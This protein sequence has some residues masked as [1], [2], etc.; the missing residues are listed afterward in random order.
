MNSRSGAV[1]AGLLFLFSQAGFAQAAG[2]DFTPYITLG[3]I[4]TDNVTLAPAGEEQDEFITL[5]NPG[6]VLGREAGRVR[7]KIA[8]QMQNLFY[9]KESDFNETHH[10]LDAIGVAEIVREHFYVDATSSI[11]QQ[12]IN[13]EEA[14]GLS[15]VSVT[16]NRAD[17]FTASVSPY[18]R[19][20]FGSTMA[21]LARYRYGIVDYD[22]GDVGELTED[23]TV[24]GGLLAL[25]SQPSERR[26]AWLGAYSR[27]RVESEDADATDTF[28]QAGLRLDYR[29]T[30]AIGLVALGGYEDNEFERTAVTLD[31]EGTFWEAGLRLEPSTRDLIELR[32]GERFFGN[33]Y[34][35]SWDHY[36][37]R[38]A[39]RAAYSEDVTTVAQSL[40][41]GSD[42][43][44]N[45]GILNPSPDIDLTDAGD[46][47]IND[48]TVIDP[49]TGVPIDGT[50]IDPVTGAPLGGLSLTSEVFVAKRLDASVAF[51]M[52]KTDTRI[53]VFQEDREFEGIALSEDERVRGVETAFEWH[54]APRTDFIAGVDYAREDFGDDDQNADL[55]HFSLGLQ[56]VFGLQTFGRLEGLRTE[57]TS[58]GNLDEYVENAVIASIT[59]RF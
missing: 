4:Y 12:V 2:W 57:R 55:T 31:P 41:G 13:A 52:A 42:D 10:Q 6:F 49:N 11:S 32:Y 53:N 58:D 3:E 51:S 24:N 50:A 28:E 23:A 40:L 33:T 44:L 18:L 45:Y 43:F 30:R 15:N 35:F 39:T 16:D 1:I 19:Q 9:A 22:E 48:S 47:P 26:L 5:V 8:Y 38:F 20:K 37:R 17:V 29:L 14:S 36:G 59:R 21:A 7:A 34:F 56:H 27:E 25:G 46:S 54:F